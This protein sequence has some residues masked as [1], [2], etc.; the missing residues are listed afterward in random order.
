MLTIPLSHE[1]VAEHRAELLAGAPTHYKV[2]VDRW[3]WGYAISTSLT[4][5][6]HFEKART[7]LGK[8][9]IV[10]RAVMR[11]RASYMLTAHIGGGLVFFRYLSGDGTPTPPV[12][13]ETLRAVDPGA[14][15]LR[16]H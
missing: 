5:L 7:P 16:P 8:R 14:W 6:R 9:L 3:R 1:H 2:P 12:V 15:Q 4:V 13:A 11:G 10:L